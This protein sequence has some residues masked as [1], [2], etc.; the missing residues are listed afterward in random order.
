VPA[1]GRGERGSGA[2]GAAAA[3]YQGVAAN[4]QTHRHALRACMWCVSHVTLSPDP[5]LT[6]R[7]LIHAGQVP[8]GPRCGPAAR[9]CPGRAVRHRLVLPG[10][11]A[12]PVCVPACPVLP[13]NRAK[14]GVEGHVRLRP[15]QGDRPSK[16]LGGLVPANLKK[17]RCARRAVRHRLVLPG[18]GAGR[19]TAR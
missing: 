19:L 4:R 14:A 12:C 15:R 6:P 2:L 13:D 18:A 7:S 8:G 5:S 3:R 16:V 17:L 9:R 1:A 11:V 10:A